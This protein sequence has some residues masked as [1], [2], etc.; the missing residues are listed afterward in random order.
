MVIGAFGSN[1]MPKKWSAARRSA[2]IQ[3]PEALTGNAIEP[4]GP[5][6]EI[7]INSVL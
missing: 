7:L 5:V 6:N 4:E 1:A 3:R 2:P